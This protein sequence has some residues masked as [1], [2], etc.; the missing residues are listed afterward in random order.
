M[1]GASDLDDGAFVALRKVRHVN[2][3]GEDC[4]KEDEN[5]DG[6]DVNSAMAKTE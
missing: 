5:K 1:S 4:V 2:G 3:E 6:G